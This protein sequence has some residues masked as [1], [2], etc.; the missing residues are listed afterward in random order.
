VITKK[1]KKLLKPATLHHKHQEMPRH[2]LIKRTD[3]SNESDKSSEVDYNEYNS[4]V[5]GDDDQSVLETE[6]S[7]EESKEESYASDGSEQLSDGD[8]T[9]NIS[10]SVVNN[11]LTDIYKKDTGKLNTILC[12]FAEMAKVTSGNQKA[13]FLFAFLK[14]VVETCAELTGTT[15]KFKDIIGTQDADVTEEP[16]KPTG[17]EDQDDSDSCGISNASDES[18]LYFL[19]SLIIE[20]GLKSVDT[21]TLS[22]LRDNLDAIAK[23]LPED[24][25]AVE[26][27]N[28][29]MRLNKMCV[30]EA[31]N[32]RTATAK[33][34]RKRA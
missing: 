23:L 28:T 6:G 2:K 33:G 1:E 15:E 18:A 7:D 4:E 12:H 32:R 9:E 8:P 14:S 16:E 19:G 5:D 30:D 20:L 17:T 31:T 10:V 27:K 29:V 22:I 21:D 3:D 26:L 25:N 24:D 13:H 34:K 11:C